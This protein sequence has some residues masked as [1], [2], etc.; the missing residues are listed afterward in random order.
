MARRLAQVLLLVIAVAIVSF[1]QT[2]GVP[3][4][5]ST[6]PPKGA[7]LAP[8]VPQILRYGP[9]YSEKYQQMGYNVAQKI[10]NVIYQLPCY[11]YCDRIGHKS[12]RTCFESDHAAHCATCLQEAYYAY[13]QTKAG[14]SVK[15]IRE[16]VNRGAFKTIDLNEAADR[17]S[18]M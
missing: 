6:P 1:A 14:K 4:Y 18:K 11:C 16:E 13:F 15:Q 3:A 12:L 17:A 5:H 2:E 8:I 7:K 10:P 9:T